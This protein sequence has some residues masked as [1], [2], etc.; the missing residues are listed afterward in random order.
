MGDQDFQQ[1][2]VRGEVEARLCVDKISRYL[3]LNG[4]GQLNS[5]EMKITGWEMDTP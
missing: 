3:V 4:G 1:A 5:D 2:L